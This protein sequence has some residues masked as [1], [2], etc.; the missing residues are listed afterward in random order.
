MPNIE[1]MLNQN[2][3]RER[4]REAIYYKQKPLSQIAKE[5]GVSRQTLTRWLRHTY[6]IQRIDVIERMYKW[7]LTD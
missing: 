6:D 2:E 4:F 1:M 5:C 3:L 7:T